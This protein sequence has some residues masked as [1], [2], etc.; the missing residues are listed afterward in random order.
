ML[1]DRL[2]RWVREVTHEELRRRVTSTL[3][4]W[5]DHCPRIRPLNFVPTP[6]LHERVIGLHF[7]C[8]PCEEI[9]LYDEESECW[10]C[11]GCEAALVAVEAYTLLVQ[12]GHASISLARRMEET[13][14]VEADHG[15]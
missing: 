14:M 8:L 5:L 13:G 15:E 10:V 11:P 6:Y 9:A 2:K 12:I 4:D 7:M 3:E 1:K